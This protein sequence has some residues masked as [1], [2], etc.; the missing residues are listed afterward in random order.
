VAH[1]VAR[2]ALLHPTRER[3]YGH[4]VR[5]PGDH[6]RSIVRSL[7]LALG[8]ASHHLEM[9]VRDGLVTEERHAGRVR[10]YPRGDDSH[11]DR[12]RL[13]MRHWN[14][15][16]LRVRVLLTVAGTPALRPVD[17]AHRLRV[18]RQLASYHLVQL[19][20]LGLVVREG[21]R[22]SPTDSWSGYVFEDKGRGT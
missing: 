4:L 22:Y 3:I 7:H 1:S 10:Y 20:R 19:R 8:T 12:N 2:E 11:V 18:S 15:R 13:Y 14:F 16:D 6:F 17:V 9:L 21:G 5:L